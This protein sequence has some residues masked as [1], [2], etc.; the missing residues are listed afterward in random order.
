ME[1]GWDLCVREPIAI[2]PYGSR[3][4]PQSDADPCF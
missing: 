4:E 1:I 2:Y 3:L